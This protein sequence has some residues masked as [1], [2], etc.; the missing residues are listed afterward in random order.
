VKGFD[1]DND[2]IV[3]AKQMIEKVMLIA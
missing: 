1:E 3:L 2:P